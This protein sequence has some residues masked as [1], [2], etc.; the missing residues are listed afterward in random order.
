MATIEH[1]YGAYLITGRGYGRSGELVQT[2]WDYP[3][4]A[5]RFGWSLRRVQ[6]IGGE[7]RLRQRGFSVLQ[8]DPARGRCP[9]SS[10]DGT[11]DCRDCGVTA[12]E[13]IEAAGA[14]LDGLC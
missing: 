6:K 14:Y 11:V 1:H 10:T 12:S 4:T 5:E 3:A 7:L 2:D 8:A 13:F 9:H